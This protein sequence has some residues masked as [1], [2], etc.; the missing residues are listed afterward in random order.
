MVPFMEAKGVKVGYLRF[1]DYGVNLLHKGI[2]VNTGYLA[3][4]KATIRRFV[5]ANKKAWLA[6]I[7]DP[8]AAVDAFLKSFPKQKKNKATFMKVLNHSLAMTHTANNQGKPF[9][10]MSDKDWRASQSILVKYTPKLKG[11]SVSIGEFYTNEFIPR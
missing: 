7:W 2:F 1:A 9:G 11:K 3:K 8:E 5:R 6:A 4:N 10:W